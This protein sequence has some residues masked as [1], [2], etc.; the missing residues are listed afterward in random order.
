[1][2]RANHHV[3]ITICV[4]SNLAEIKQKILEATQILLRIL[5]RITINYA[6]GF[7]GLFDDQEQNLDV[8]MDFQYLRDE[9]E[10]TYENIMWC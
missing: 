1:M 3:T 8:C 9:F 2:D 6:E 5:A 4:V 10:T 7:P